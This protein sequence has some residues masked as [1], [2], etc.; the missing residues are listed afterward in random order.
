MKKNGK[1]LQRRQNW[2]QKQDRGQ[3]FPCG[4]GGQHSDRTE[5][6]CAG[7]TR[8]ASSGRRPLL[9][10][11]TGEGRPQR[12]GKS[13]RLGAVSD[14]VRQEGTLWPMGKKEPWSRRQDKGAQG[15]RSAPCE[16]HNPGQVTGLPEP[17]APQ[18]KGK[19][20]L[21]LK[22]RCEVRGAWVA[23]SDERLLTS[24]QVTIPR[25]WDRAPCQVPCC[26]WSL[27]KILFLTRA[28][29]LTKIKNESKKNCSE[30]KEG[31]RHGND[32]CSR[33]STKD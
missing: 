19:S 27:L 20:L 22:N 15:L 31:N 13:R 10:G 32:L 29:S 11:H 18:R 33:V 3:G 16:P 12:V 23:Q 4:L 9:T 1:R 28:N 26:A 14:P 24:A 5:S 8:N 25:S 21:V 2:Q 30:V 6:L 17:Q 7:L